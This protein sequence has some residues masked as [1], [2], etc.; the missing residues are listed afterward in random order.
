LCHEDY[1]YAPI[2]GRDLELDRI[3]QDKFDVETITEQL[4]RFDIFKHDS[5][6]IICLANRDIAPI[7]VTEAILSAYEN[8]KKKIEAFVDD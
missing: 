6:Q 2:K 4:K 5:E 8:G 3:L 1:E 7:M